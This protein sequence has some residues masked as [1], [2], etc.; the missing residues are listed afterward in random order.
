MA[1]H[2]PRRDGR[3]LKLPGLLLLVVLL[4]TSKQLELGIHFE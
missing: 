4:A 1:T 3:A 2:G